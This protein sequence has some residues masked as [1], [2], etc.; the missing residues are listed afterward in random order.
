MPRYQ[1]DGVPFSEFRTADAKDLVHIHNLAAPVRLSNDF[2]QL[3]ES[4][5]RL[6]NQFIHGVAKGERI[7]HYRIYS[8]VMRG[9]ALM[10]GGTLRWPDVRVGYLRDRKSESA[11]DSFDL[12]LGQAAIEFDA[13]VE[14]LPRKSVLEVLGFDKKARRYVCPADCYSEM[15]DRDFRDYFS[16]EPIRLAQLSP[17]S[18]DSI[19][20]YCCVCGRRS[21]ITRE[22]CAFCNSNARAEIDGSEVC[23][24]CAKEQPERL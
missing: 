3:F 7:T 13:V 5:R 15:M 17:N 8:D 1:P 16:S 18:P 11:V 21:Q 24:V 10:N 12:A 6:R 23:L 14:A 20:L 9:F 22:K 4:S 2:E 19:F